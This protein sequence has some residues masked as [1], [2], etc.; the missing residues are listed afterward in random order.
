MS[1]FDSL[2][3]FF[4]MGGHGV[5]VWS[6]WGVTAALLL[7]CFWQA[8]LERRALLKALSRR[9]RRERARTESPSIPTPTEVS[10]DA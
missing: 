6:A 8:K 3:A 5:Y 10:D 1:A 2:G 7:L 9:A 4:A